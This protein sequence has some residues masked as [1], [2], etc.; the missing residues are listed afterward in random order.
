[1]SKILLYSLYYLAY[2]PLWAS[3]VFIDLI[4]IIDNNNSNIYTEIISVCIIIALLLISIIAVIIKLQFCK[5]ENS[6][7]YEIL[8]SKE[9]KTETA[10]FLLSYILPL[11]AFDFTKWT[12]VC[13]FL[14]SFSTFLYLMDK[15][16]IFC[17]NIFLE[18]RRFKFYE[19]DI[20]SNDGVVAKTVILSRQALT[21][22]IGERI[23]L[24]PLNNEIRMDVKNE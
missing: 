14:I 24:K 2:L 16:N 12:G 18:T 1:M 21:L 15:Y 7:E 8:S 17:A 13:L 19:C 20:M 4:N 3:I 5:K 22:K 9:K 11:S 10:T 6:I 23:L